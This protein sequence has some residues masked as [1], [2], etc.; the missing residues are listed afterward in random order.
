MTINSRLNILQES[1]DNSSINN[2]YYEMSNYYEN[3]I[4]EA[5]GQS[6]SKERMQLNKTG[7][8]VLDIIN[9]LNNKRDIDRVIDT[10][11]G[12]SKEEIRILKDGNLRRK[13]NNDSKGL[14]SNKGKYSKNV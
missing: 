13:L 4:S 7:L 1:L 10:Q 8:K 5:F 14:N 12:L 11:K 6:I 3:C 2:S 9:K